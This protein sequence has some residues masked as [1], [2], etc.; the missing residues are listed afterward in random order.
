MWSCSAKDER[1][2]CAPPSMTFVRLKSPNIDSAHPWTTLPLTD[3]CVDVTGRH[4]SSA[5]IRGKCI[6]GMWSCS[7]LSASKVQIQTLHILGQPSPALDSCVHVTGRRPSLSSDS[8][9]V[10]RRHVE[11]LSQWGISRRSPPRAHLRAP[12]TL[13][14][15]LYVD[16]SHK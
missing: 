16:F 13:K 3:S 10:H 7:P 4:L 15:R 9:Q 14:H 11:L 1:S 12:Q 8:R 2:V 6:E 5:L